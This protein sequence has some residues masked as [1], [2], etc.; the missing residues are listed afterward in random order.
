MLTL[1]RAD[2]IHPGLTRI[3]YAVSHS[4]PG[5]DGTTLAAELHLKVMDSQTECVLIV[6]DATA[7][8]PKE[9]LEKMCAYLERLKIGIEQRKETWLPI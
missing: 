8:T 5:R 2:K 7:A 3:D 1:N 9:A 4:T 6:P